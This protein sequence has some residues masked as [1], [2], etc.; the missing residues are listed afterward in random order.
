MSSNLSYENVLSREER[1]TFAL[2]ALYAKR[3]Y[4]RYRMSKFEE[5]DLY[6]RNKEFLVSENIITFTDTDG[7]LMALKPDV[8]LS[9]IKNS[10]AEDGLTKVFYD[11]HVYRV[12]GGTKNFREIM[13][14]GLECIGDVG[15]NEIREVL[16]LAVGSLRALSESFVL[17][18]SQLDLINALLRYFSF[19][20]AASASIIDHLGRK[21]TDGIKA[22]CAE[23]GLG[24]DARD[25]LLL[26]A[27]TYGAPDAVLPKLEPLRLNRE[28]SEAI[29]A[30]AEA[31]SGL[32]EGVSVDFSV[33]K[34]GSYYNG[35]A[36]V[37]FIE[38]VP[39]EILRGGQYDKLAERV[40]GRKAG[41]IGFAV[42][43]DEL[44]KQ[45]GDG[46]I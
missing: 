45:K 23:A 33:T 27:G 31:L 46:A 5:Y 15:Q 43:L 12:S 44:E 11:E 4:S 39:T 40:S 13:Q 18:V 9:I 7:R 30:L 14:V 17:E 6:V 35:V 25:A 19:D 10:R 29:D 21:N 24:E 2:R 28:C 3:G 8:T 16:S 34:S 20:N 41:A 42:Y 26:L 22:V 37:G 1:A 32:P 36:F 38:G